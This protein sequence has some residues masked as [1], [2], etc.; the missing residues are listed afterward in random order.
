MEDDD[1]HVRQTWP[2]KRKTRA[3]LRTHPVHN[4]CACGTTMPVRGTR[5]LVAAA[6]ASKGNA[7]SSS[8]MDVSPCFFFLQMNDH[9]V[10]H[11]DRVVVT[12]WGV[13]DADGGSELEPTSC[14]R[15]NPQTS[16][17]ATQPAQSWLC[18][19]VVAS[20]S[21]PPRDSRS[22]VRKLPTERL[23]DQP[24]RRVGLKC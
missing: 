6:C 24:S 9:C 7:C 3:R 20:S 18:V 12:W 10:N 5:A 22:A 16:P 13:C 4:L 1:A 8:A 2:K 15:A 17:L 19:M 23:A 11:V 21:L 14:L